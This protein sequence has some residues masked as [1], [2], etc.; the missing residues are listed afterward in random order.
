ME[1][2]KIT[3]EK[4]VKRNSNYIKTRDD[5][6][7][8]E[9]T[10]NRIDDEGNYELE[11][12]IDCSWLQNKKNISVLELR[13]RIEPWLTALFQSEHLSLLVGS[14]L[15]HAISHIALSSKVPEGEEKKIVDIPATGMGNTDFDVFNDCIQKKARESAEST[16]RENG[17]FE[18][19]I[20]T[21]NEL[22][23]GLEIFNNYTD[24]DIFCE[25]GNDKLK[26]KTKLL[27]KN[28]EDK[29]QLFATSILETEC[30]I[31]SGDKDKVAEAFSVLINFLMSFASR[32]GTRDRLN[33]F[34]TNYDRLL[35]EG[36][37]L[38]GLRFIDRFVGALNP[39]FR[40]SRI[41]VDMH[42]NPPGIRGEP[43]YLEGVARYTK[44]HGSVDWIQTNDEIRKFGLPLG[45]KEITPYLQA[46]GLYGVTALQLMIYPNS[47]KDKETAM[48]PYVELFRDFAAAICRPNSTIV[49][50]GYSFG[51]DHINRV[52]SDMLTIPSTHLV[53]IS[54]DD[55]LRRI[56]SFY[57]KISRSSQISLLIGRELG[58]ISKLT[59]NYLPKASIDKTTYKLGEI[60]KN[61][62]NQQIIEN[63]KDK[64]GQ[65][66]Q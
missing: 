6:S 57:E 51:D 65:D 17:N 3:K 9:F 26:E 1:E 14:G 46:P 40:S 7:P 66:G 59:N 36:A 24:K 11:N 32:T 56:M 63:E 60:L 27:E 2:S 33:I 53:I 23:Q 48:F 41:D 39:V 50:Y 34:T 45:A 22:R 16:G 28:I 10:V 49:T 5:I 47:S 64:K 52:I 18:D 54:L 61:R 21:A 42:Y 35:E 31:I 62:Y 38:A 58:D 37:D 20:R 13:S 55:P 43:R 4:E 12:E 15:T 8:V 44:M 29:I 25:N 19:L 30:N